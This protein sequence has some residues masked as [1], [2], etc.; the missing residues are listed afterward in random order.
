MRN[1]GS[2]HCE[3]AF[4]EESV[5]PGAAPKLLA[6]CGAGSSW[7]SL[8][9]LSKGRR[10]EETGRKWSW[11][12]WLGAKPAVETMRFRDIGSYLQAAVDSNGVALGR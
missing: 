12:T 4:P 8:P 10:G 6:A 7:Q 3:L 5:F 9:L 11:A 1:R 2:G